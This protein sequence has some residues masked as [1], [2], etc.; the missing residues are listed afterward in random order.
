MSL[1]SVGGLIT[2]LFVFGLLG[3]V[4]GLITYLF[5]V[6]LLCVVGLII[7]VLSVDGLPRGLLTID[8]INIIT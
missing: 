1:V 8:S 6:G 5:V 2:S 4:G 3:V 7:L